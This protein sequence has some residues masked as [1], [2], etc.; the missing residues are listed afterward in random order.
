MYDEKIPSLPTDGI[1]TINMERNL[2][3]PDFNPAAF[4]FPI[5]D[6]YRVS[7]HVGNLTA[8]DADGVGTNLYI[9]ILLIEYPLCHRK[10]LH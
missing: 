5:T 3:S 10:L 6:K 9:G 7:Q 2:N 1:L 8:T 4:L